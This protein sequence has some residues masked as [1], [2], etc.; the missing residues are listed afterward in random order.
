MRQ[1]TIDECLIVTGAEDDNFDLGDVFT[2]IENHESKLLLLGT[3]LAL[4]AGYYGASL[5]YAHFGILGVL[6]GGVNGVLAGVYLA[7]IA[8][9]TTYKMV[10][11]SYYFFG[12]VSEE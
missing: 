8:F 3:M 11:Q 1:L 5:G 9:I 6:T 2:M 12:L 4:G 7:P 10:Q